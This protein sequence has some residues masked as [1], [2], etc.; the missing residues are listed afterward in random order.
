MMVVNLQG[1]AGGI[2]ALSSIQIGSVNAEI[3]ISHKGTEHQDAITVFDIVGYLFTSDRSFI[4]SHVK[5]MILANH[6]LPQQSG[7]HWDV[8]LFGKVN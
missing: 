6:T 3:E 2:D 4:E 8:V 7:S 1:F 5:R